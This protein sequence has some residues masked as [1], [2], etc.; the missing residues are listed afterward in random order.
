[1]RGLRVG[2]FIFAGAGTALAATV[3]LAAPGAGSAA[4]ATPAL[5]ALDKPAFTA[6]PAEQL[7]LGKA[8]P[9][10]DWSTVILREQR[11]V[12]YDD[13]GRIGRIQEQ[14]GL[15]GDAAAAYERVTPAPYDQLV[16]AYQLAQHRLAAIGARP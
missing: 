4:P 1:M 6:T 12:S 11:E 16:S 8:A 7:A 15:T 10:G 2:T 3:S 9:T 5:R 13:R 14:L